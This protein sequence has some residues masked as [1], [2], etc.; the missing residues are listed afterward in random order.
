MLAQRK[1]VISIVAW[2]AISAVCPEIVRPIG[3]L[4]TS[5]WSFAKMI[6]HSERHQAR[7]TVRSP[8]K[9]KLPQVENIELAVYV[10]K[11]LERRRRFS[12]FRES[13]YKLHVS[14]L[15]QFIFDAPCYGRR[16]PFGIEIRYQCCLIGDSYNNRYQIYGLRWASIATAQESSP[17]HWLRSVLVC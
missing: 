3:G 5:A 9:I 4:E 14:K 15:I 17:P 10:D 12:G 6:A 1:P 13:E 16:D 8:S 11:F 2:Q 7:F